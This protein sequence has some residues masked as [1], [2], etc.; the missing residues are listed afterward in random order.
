MKSI[1]HIPHPTIQTMHVLLFKS[2]KYPFGQADIH[3]PSNKYNV[4]LQL[5]QK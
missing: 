5:V 1:V 2:V 3:T 4:E